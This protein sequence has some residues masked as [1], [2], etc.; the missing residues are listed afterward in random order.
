MERELA[1]GCVDLPAQRARD[2]SIS[3]SRGRRTARFANRDGEPG[4]P[5]PL[6]APALAPEATPHFAPEG[7]PLL[8]LAT[9]G[10]SEAG[11]VIAAFAPLLLNGRR[12]YC[13]DGGGVFNPYRLSAWVRRQR[14]DPAAVLERVFVSRAYTCHQLLGALE[15]L[16]A[17]L[18]EEPEPPPVALLGVDR[19]F[20]DEDLPLWER[21]YLFKRILEEAGDLRR[22]GTPVLMTF[23]GEGG[24][25]PWTRQIGKAALVL[26]D[27]GNALRRIGAPED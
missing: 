24:K 3:R 16:A 1:G 13:L 4:R 15:T 25:T 7:A 23:V 17:P 18:A 10:Q 9:P 27:V 14:L 11:R 20:I 19:L 6:L 22:Q 5:P 21:R 26:E 2:R 8:A 12:L